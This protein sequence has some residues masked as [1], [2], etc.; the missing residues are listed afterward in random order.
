MSEL[1]ETYIDIMREEAELF[2][3]DDSL[4]LMDTMKLLD[5]FTL[6]PELSLGWD[7]K[8]IE[9]TW[10]NKK[11]S[12]QYIFY[13]N[14]ITNCRVLTN[15]CSKIITDTILLRGED[16]DESIS[17]SL[18]FM[19]MMNE[20]IVAEIIESEYAQIQRLVWLNNHTN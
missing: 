17:F 12:V 11:C 19:R 10:F 15:D 9:A 3:T 8:S 13:E 14:G 16:L 4:P 1:I 20:N 18:Y 6:K 7:E 5:T 2:G